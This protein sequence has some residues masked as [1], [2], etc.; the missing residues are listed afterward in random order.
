MVSYTLAHGNSRIEIEK[1]MDNEGE[2]SEYGKKHCGQEKTYHNGL[3]LARP[4]VPLESLLPGAVDEL[5]NEP[6]LY[7]Q[8]IHYHMREKNSK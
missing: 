3:S 6:N 8:S 1:E 2:K 4:T 5:P 7:L